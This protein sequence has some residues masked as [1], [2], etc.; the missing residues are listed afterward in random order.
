MSSVLDAVRDD[1]ILEATR[2]MRERIALAI[3]DEA[4]PPRDL[5]A[6]TKR[7]FDLNREIREVMAEEEKRRAKGEL[8]DGEYS[9][10]AE[11]SPLGDI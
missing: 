3:D 2:A 10:A 9:G 4:T 11:D 5:A 1:D 8:A 7:L 6:L